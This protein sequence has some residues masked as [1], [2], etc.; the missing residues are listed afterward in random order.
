MTWYSI[1]RTSQP[2]QSSF[3]HHNS[4]HQIWVDTITLTLDWGKHFNS[5]DSFNWT[6]SMTWY[7]IFRMSQPIQLSFAHH[8]SLHQIWADIITLT[9]DWGKRF[10]PVDSFHCTISMTWYS[11]FGCLSRSNHPSHITMRFI[12]SEIQM[13]Q[14]FPRSTE[15]NALIQLIFFIE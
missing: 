11:I 7:S 6:I 13:M 1:L 3:T 8:N 2:I 15:V 12:K 4:L 14:S 9:L 10:N 5:V